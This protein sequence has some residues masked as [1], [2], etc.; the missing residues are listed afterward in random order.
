MAGTILNKYGTSN[1]SVTCTITS[2]AT[3]G[4]RGST[5]VDNSTN[6]FTDALVMVQAK[7]AASSTSSTGFVDVYAFACVDG[8][9]IFSGGASGADGAFS[10]PLP[11][12][13]R[14]GRLPTVANSTVYDGGP[15]SVASA[16]GGSL[17]QKWGVV[18][19]NESGAT[20]DASTGEVI[21]QGVYGSYT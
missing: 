4:Q 7:T 17:P 9:T 16:F 2:L 18:V 3:A 15:W 12:L 21:Y 11:S 5:A 8:G 20:L 13:V 19:D 14:L 6:L 1:Q 10:G